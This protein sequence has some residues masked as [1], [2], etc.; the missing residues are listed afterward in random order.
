[1]KILPK[2][3]EIAA[4]LAI[5]TDDSFESPEDMAKEC[6]KAVLL[7]AARRETF[8]LAVSA[9]PPFEFFWPFLYEREALR[10]SEELGAMPGERKR[11]LL[12]MHS[13]ILDREARERQRTA[14]AERV[15]GLNWPGPGQTLTIPGGK[16][17]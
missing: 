4:A 1:M 7:E 3:N 16:R 13:P 12:R 9:G 15:K 5:I 14:E 8:A 10:F 11:M 2:K 6:V 17:T